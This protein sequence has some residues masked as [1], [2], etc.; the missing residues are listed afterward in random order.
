MVAEGLVAEMAYAFGRDG[1]LALR[2]APVVF[3]WSAASVAVACWI[4]MK[5]VGAGRTGGLFYSFGVF[6]SA[7]AIMLMGLLPWL[8]ADATIQATFQTRTIQS[9]YLKNAL[10]YFLPLIVVFVLPAFHAVVAL[11]RETKVGDRA[12]V[13]RLIRR[14]FGTLPLRGVPPPRVSHLSVLLVLAAVWAM[15]TTNYLLDRLVAGPYMNLFSILVEIRVAAWFVIAL[16]S[17][18]WYS[19]CLRNLLRA[20]S[21]GAAN[22]AVATEGNSPLPLRRSE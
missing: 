12:N 9:G 6:L 19:S 22:R 18:A 3:V 16:T 13:A 5:W 15:V 10:Y 17:V 8:P 11:E 14:D 20:I 2:L 21:P 7:M 4:D 1:A